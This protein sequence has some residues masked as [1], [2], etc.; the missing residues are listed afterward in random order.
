MAQSTRPR[1]ARSAAGWLVVALSTALIP[2][3]SACYVEGPEVPVHGDGYDPQFYDG[4]VVYYDD[5]GRPFYY[6][7]GAAV[8]VPVGSPFYAGLV[9]HWRMH[10]PAYNSWHAHYGNRYRT[11][12]SS[13]G[14]AGHRR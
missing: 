10:R 13:Y 11:Y 4:Y 6:T 8:W 3:G 14:R 5:V 12:R 2:T 9:N 1:S 7:D